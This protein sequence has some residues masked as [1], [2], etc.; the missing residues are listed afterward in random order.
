MLVGLKYT[1][2]NIRVFH[3]PRMSLTIA[4]SGSCAAGSTRHG[5]V[6]LFFS[7]PT[8]CTMRQ[9]C[10]GRE[11]FM[12]IT[13]KLS[14]WKKGILLVW[15]E[16]LRSVLGVGRRGCWISRRC[17]DGI[18]NAEWEHACFW[19]SVNQSR[20]YRIQGNAV[21]NQA[22]SFSLKE[23]RFPEILTQTS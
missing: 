21:R 2:Q 18:G 5:F 4:T 16:S 13:T 3:L 1:C 15:F 6:P 14:R 17:Q 19:C 22:T 9:R 11:T 20:F 8:L 7:F 12:A 23:K 10:P